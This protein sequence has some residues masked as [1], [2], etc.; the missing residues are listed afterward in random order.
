MNIEKYRRFINA[1]Q[2][3]MAAVAEICLT[4]YWLKEKGKRPFKQEEMNKI[5]R[6]IK[7]KIPDI[8]IEE[9]FFAN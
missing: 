4:S 3:D 1:T 8:T 6:H 7:M 9:L 2:A 5:F